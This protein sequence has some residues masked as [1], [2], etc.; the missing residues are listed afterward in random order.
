M[1][2]ITKKQNLLSLWLESFIVINK[3]LGKLVKALLGILVLMAAIVA[4]CAFTLGLSSLITRFVINIFSAFCATVIFQ[5]IAA[6]IL[7]TQQPL[8]EAFAGS[9]WPTIFQFIASIL[10]GISCIPVALVAIL[11]LK[12]S[13]ILTF[14]LFIAWL[15]LAVRFLY[16]FIAIAIDNKGPIEGLVYSWKL[17]GGTNYLDALLVLL[18]LMGSYILIAIFF[19]FVGLALRAIIPL[20]FAN[21]FDLTHLSPIWW[22]GGLILVIL[23][24]FYHLAIVTFL[25]LVFLNR[26]FQL[27]PSTP[28]KEQQDTV[29]IPLPELETPTGENGP[30]QIPSNNESLQVLPQTDDPQKMTPSA[31]VDQHVEQHHPSGMESLGITKTSVNTTEAD[32]NEI[33]QHLNQVYTP[34]PKDTIQHTEEDRMPTILFD[35]DLA[36]QLEQQFLEEHQPQPSKDDNSSSGDDSIQLSK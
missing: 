19:T 11:T 33:T 7:Q 1:D 9:V 3:G 13:P 8:M 34:R 22:I 36:K 32:T 2:I 26:K 18:I 21:S 35:D 15:F 17:T 5:V 12:I 4:V 27:E 10:I 14:L 23:Y 24:L 25:I 20:Y 31:A 16:T 28:V 30:Q 6:H 29:F